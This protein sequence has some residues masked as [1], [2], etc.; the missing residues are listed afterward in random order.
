MG[1]ERMQGTMN[2]ALKRCSIAVLASVAVVFSAESMALAASESG[3]AVPTTWAEKRA[4]KLAGE[5]IGGDY[6]SGRH[7]MAEKKLREG[8]QLCM[9][10]KCAPAIMARLHRDLGVVYI[11]GMKK[12]EEGKDEFSAALTADSNVALAPSMVE[13]PAVKQAFDEVKAGTNGSSAAKETDKAPEVTAKEPD[14]KKPEE[15][16][17]EAENTAPAKEET[18]RESNEPPAKPTERMFKN[19]LSLSVQEDFVLHSAT[20][21]ACGTGSAYKCYDA[22]GARQPAYDPGSYVPGGN[23]VAAGGFQPGTLRV[24]VGYDRAF[25]RRFS[26]GLRLGA[27][28]QGQATITQGDSAVLALHGEARAAVWFGRE[29]FSAFLRP[30]AVLSGGV[31]ETDSKVLV[32]L[33]RNGDPNLYSFNAWKRSGKGFVGVGAGLVAAITKRGGPMAEL[34]Y[35]QFMGPSTSA[36]ALQIGYMFG[37]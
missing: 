1:F 36:V 15:K 22:N 32:Q 14:Q 27:M 20:E 16:A 34:R 37:F 21:N 24:L 17:K 11:A 28:I 33:Q 4:V 35:L 26:A 2:R 10:Q 18:A 13:M 25:G 5:A 3:E 9:V 6:W 12:V 29:P 7:A 30:Y 8:I 23:Q 19:W 31:A